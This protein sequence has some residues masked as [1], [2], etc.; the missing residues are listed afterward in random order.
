MKRNLIKICIFTCLILVLSGIVSA[1]SQISTCQELQ[2]IENN[3]SSDYELLNDIDCSDT[4]SWNGGSGFEPIDNFSG[5]LNGNSYRITDLH[6]NRPNE[7]SV[8]IFSGGGGFEV[9]NIRI[10]D[11]NVRGGD[12]TA[13]LIGRYSSDG[14]VENLALIDSEVNGDRDVGG[15]A[16][17]DD[18]SEG[19]DIRDSLII[20]TEIVG[21]SGRAGGF[22]TR[23]G[24]SVTL[25]RSTIEGGKVEG[26]SQ[27]GGLIGRTSSSSG[28]I[29]SYSG[30]TVDGSN[31]VGG[32]V[33]HTSAGASDF[34]QVYSYS[35]VINGNGVVGTD[36]SSDSVND[37]YFDE[38]RAGTDFD[39]YGEPLTT[40][41]MT[42]EDATENMENFDFDNIWITRDGDYPTFRWEFSSPIL[43]NPFPEDGS[44]V[45]DLETDVRVN[46]I[47]PDGATVTLYQGEPGDGTE[48]REVTVESGGIAE[49]DFPELSSGES[50]EWSAQACEG[51]SCVD[52]GPWT[53]DVDT[54]EW[55]LEMIR[56]VNSAVVGEDYTFEARLENVGST[57]GDTGNLE[58]YHDRDPDLFGFNASQNLDVGESMIVEGTTSFDSAVPHEVIAEAPAHD[59]MVSEQVIVSSV[60]GEEDWMNLVSF[61]LDLTGPDSGIGWDRDDA[62][63]NIDEDSA[64][65]VTSGQSRDTD[66]N[67]GFDRVFFYDIY[68][69]DSYEDYDQGNLNEDSLLDFHEPPL[70]GDDQREYLLE[71]KG[72]V[73]NSEQAVGSFA[74]ADGPQY[75]H[76]RGTTGPKLYEVSDFEQTDQVGEQFGRFKDNEAV[77]AQRP[78]LSD[79]DMDRNY[80]PN[81]QW[82]SQDYAQEISFTSGEGQAPNWM[83]VET[84]QTI[85]DENDLFG[86][87]G[88]QWIDKDEIQN[89]PLA[90]R[91][92]IDD[93]WNHRMSQM[94]HPYLI[95][96]PDGD[97]W[98]IG[99]D[100]IDDGYSPVPTGT[101]GLFRGEDSSYPDNSVVADP[102]SGDYGF[103][104]GDDAS[105]FLVYQDSQTRNVDTDQDIL[106]VASSQDTCVLDNSQFDDI[107]ESD[108]EA[109]SFSG[110]ELQEERM[111]YQDGETVT[112]DQEDDDTQR[113]IACFDGQWWGDW[114][115][116]FLEDTAEFDLGETGFISFL[117][118]NPTDSSKDM[119]LELNP[120][121]NDDDDREELAQMTSFE[122]TGTD[123]VE[124]TVPAS[125]STIQ[126]LEV[127]ANRE[128]DT[129]SENGYDLEVFGISSD[130]SLSGADQVDLLI[131]ED[132]DL[133][134][135]SSQTRGI[136]GLT[137]V[138]LAVIALMASFIFFFSN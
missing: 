112:F 87:E 88:V 85:C 64:A 93:S 108:L 104:G 138:Q 129:T 39:V 16:A 53:F 120:R 30:T 14:R 2:D 132:E 9:R 24:G 117:V 94:D 124:F 5:E 75:C 65:G 90:Y 115:I 57:S 3:P 36:E 74:C 92:G 79:T 122:S 123:E 1:Q 61:N 114:P 46:Y 56:F 45:N 50:Y 137:A 126:R 55:N 80:D 73:Q 38:E 101:S 41:E 100:M 127:N 107:D 128:V 47:G 49:S 60:P 40:S 51:G 76:F 44:E 26:G 131:E 134:G 86:A 32:V 78:G 96:D 59:L 111:L 58:L 34:G 63:P 20:D 99:D 17:D 42:G 106:G 23:S 18:H 7:N 22:D 97:H 37:V 102:T 116:V 4:E 109:G 110:D 48:L 33:G 71:E 15:V 6:I 133:V 125:S 118:I 62:W 83:T 8:G 70:C 121:A 28:I 119:E 52:A 27:V 130:G 67:T 12:N 69:Q 136:P 81:P 68:W 43:Y 135:T 95:S 54:A 13:V 25:E 89:N 82:Y 31:D 10:I 84:S 72:Q 29:D 105:E 21:Q 103:C 91:R 19:I 11:A 66:P 77:C 35:E 98:D 113:T